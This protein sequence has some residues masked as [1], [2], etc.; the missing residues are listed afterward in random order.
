LKTEEV[1]VRQQILKM[2]A[3]GKKSRS[4]KTLLQQ[5]R[6]STLQLQFNQKQI[7]LD[8][9]LEGLALLIGTSN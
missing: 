4:K 1:L 9:L 7:N 6:I 5:E 3:G 8:E 2:M